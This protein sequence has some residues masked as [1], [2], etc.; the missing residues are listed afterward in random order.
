MLVVHHGGVFVE[1]HPT[2]YIGKQ[3]VLEVEPDY[4][5]Y[6]SLLATIKRPGGPMFSSLWYHDPYV[7]EKLIRLRD[8]HGCSRMKDIA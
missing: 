7:E 3:T 8:D 6:F 2:K 1:F 4:W 5:S